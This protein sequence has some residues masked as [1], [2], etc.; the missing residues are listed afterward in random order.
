MIAA[1]DCP[2]SRAD[3]TV[4]RW[5]AQTLPEAEARRF[6][7]HLLECERCQEAVRTAASIRSG[8]RHN[9]A[10]PTGLRGR[11]LI[12]PLGV[13]AALALVLFR[14]AGDP[15]ARLADP[16]PAPAFIPVPVR[17][18]QIAPGVGD[19]GMQA[20]A[21]G[22]YRRAARLLDSAAALDPTPATQFFLGVSQ[23]KSGNAEDA[24]A[25]L[26]AVVG[27]SVNPYAAEAALWLAK[28]WLRAGLPDSADAVLRS[29]GRRQVDTEIATHARALIDSIREVRR[30]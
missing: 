9:A 12:V 20:Y 18:T 1:N 3:D 30:R 25:A 16:G 11:R 8:L 27:D 14:P 19:R 15:L 17:T 28:A 22:N 23:L 10:V 26:G 5:V 29:L 24:A 7:E 13:A 2:E 21:A 6:E 4:A